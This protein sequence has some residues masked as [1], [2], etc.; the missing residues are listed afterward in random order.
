MLVRSKSHGILLFKRFINV[1]K[2]G[3]SKASVKVYILASFN[4][5]SVLT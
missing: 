3:R 1:H 4:V 5:D 2:N